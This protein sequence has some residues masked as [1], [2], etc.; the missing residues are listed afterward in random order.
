[1]RWVTLSLAE[2]CGGDF[3]DSDVWI[4]KARFTLLMNVKTIIKNHGTS[5]GKHKKNS[6]KFGSH[7]LITGIKLIQMKK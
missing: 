1:M 2:N 3:L 6:S 5:R 7:S 4:H